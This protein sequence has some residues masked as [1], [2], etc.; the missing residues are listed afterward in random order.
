[1]LR[2]FDRLLLAVLGSTLLLHSVIAADLHTPTTIIPQS[3]FGLHIH[4]L[5]FP[6]PTTPWPSMAVPQWRLWDAVVS[7]PDLEPTKGQWQFE[8][9]DLY[10]SLAQQH[11]TGLLLPLAMTPTWAAT[12]RQT[13]SEPKN[14]EDWRTYVRTV[15]SRYKG[16]IQAYEIWNEPNLKDFWTG[17][18]NQMLTLTKEAS[19][20]IHSLDPQAL[21]VSPSATADYGIPWLVEFLKK[22]GGQFVDVVG[23]HFYLNPNTSLPEQIVPLIRRVRQVVDES[24][25]GNK[26][27]WNT[28]MG[29]L[30][31]AQFDSE[32][33]AAAFLARAYI[34]AWAA[35]IQRFYWYAWD[36]R[37]LAIVTYKE[38]EHR[39]TPAGNA[40]QNM[41][42]W[43]VGARME[44]CTEGADHTWVCQLSRSKCRE[45]IV[46][47]PLGTLKFDIP[48]AWHVKGA[49]LLLHEPHSLDGSSIEIGFAPTLLTGRA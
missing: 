35:G 19:A 31:P 22:G 41:Q 9:L 32:E 45:W 24:G 47:N 6:S 7:W 43:L 36:N 49:T 2:F 16:R 28:E 20:I 21:V 40:Y 34:L 4:H 12:W 10:V 15:V 5:N 42:Q 30:R 33:L 37:S 27:I 17:T 25:S 39:V 38:A 48:R 18:T 11:G 8:R 26:P 23:Y 44:S 1:M 46:W 13:N 3:Y 29:W 14:L